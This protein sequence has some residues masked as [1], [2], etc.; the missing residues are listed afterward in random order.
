MKTNMK[1]YPNAFGGFLSEL[2][3]G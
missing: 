1:A 3:N 2:E